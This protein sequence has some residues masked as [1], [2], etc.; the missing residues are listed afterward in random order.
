MNATMKFK[1]YEWPYNPRELKIEQQ[2]NLN[3][4]NLPF[5][6]T[7]IQNLNC[8]KKIISGSGEFFG[9]D[10]FEKYNKLC[11][12]YKEDEK[13]YLSIPG[14]GTFLVEFKKLNMNCKPGPKSVYYYFEFWETLNVQTTNEALI[15]TYHVV[16]NG[17]TIFDI[18]KMYS[19][20]T[21]QIFKL[22]PN[23]KRPDDIKPG[24]KVMLK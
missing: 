12:V 8:D 23:I 19:K 10:C 6:G 17:E 13:G 24:D 21:A 5:V 2:K 4:I 20:T 9:D 1:D 15:A 16:K 7:I 14:V 22:N 11:E 18:A 3:Q